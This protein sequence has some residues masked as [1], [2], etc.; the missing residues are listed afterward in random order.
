MQNPD[1]DYIDELRKL[2]MLFDEGIISEEEFVLL[3]RAQII[4]TL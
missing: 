3:L 4:N 2:K 1:Y